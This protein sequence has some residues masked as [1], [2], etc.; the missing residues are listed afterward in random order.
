MHENLDIN[1]QVENRE[2]ERH[3]PDTVLNYRKVSTSL[4]KGQ[5]EAI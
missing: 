2:E 1:D 5:E 3:S 4:D